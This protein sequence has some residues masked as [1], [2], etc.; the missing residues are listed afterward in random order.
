MTPLLEVRNV[1]VGYERDVDI[2]RDVSIRIE[3]GSLTGMIGLNGAGKTTLTKTIYGFLKP[4][5]GRIHYKGEEITAVEPH[6][7]LARGMWFLPQ[8]SSLFP[9]LTVED[10]LRLLFRQL[11][12]A[13]RDGAQRLEQCFGTFPELRLSR[14]RRAGD[15]SGGQRKMLECAKVAIVRPELLFVD[16]PSV[17]L[18]PKVALQV[19]EQITAFRHQGMTVFLIDHNVRKVIELADYIYVLNMGRIV[20]QGPR[21]HFAGE[22]KQQVQKWLGL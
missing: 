10:N 3:P 5:R 6:T 11:G 8:D 9:Y 1:T 2:L 12:L 13:A 19:Y 20:N 22:L 16:E 4:T 17:G 15:L 7:L 14:R 21:S 18:A